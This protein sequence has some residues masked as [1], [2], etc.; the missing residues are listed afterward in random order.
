M[1]ETDSRR[2]LKNLSLQPIEKMKE[3]ELIKI[4]AQ[5]QAHIQMASVVNASKHLK[6]NTNYL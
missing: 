3:T 1:I 6:N 2:H 5:R 4:F